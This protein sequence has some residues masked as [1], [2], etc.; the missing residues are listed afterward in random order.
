MYNSI[1]INEFPEKKI[2]SGI[3]L[4]LDEMISKLEYHNNDDEVSATET[5]IYGIM[6]DMIDKIIID[7]DNIPE[8]EDTVSITE[9]EKSVSLE[10]D[11]NIVLP[12]PPTDIEKYLYAKEPKR[13]QI[14]LFNILPP[15]SYICSIL[16]LSTVSVDTLFLV[17]IAAFYFFY[18]AFSY[19][20]FGF[21]SF[22]FATH[23]SLVSSFTPFRIDYIPSVDVFLPIC[24]EPIAVIQNTW[25][26]VSQLEYPHMNIYVLND[27]ADKE[28][29]RALAG[30]Y[31]FTYIQRTDKPHLKK[32]GNLRNA[33][34]QT[35][36]DYIAI[37]DADFC[38]RHDFLLETIPIMVAD[39]S[40][41]ILQTPQYFR[42]L[43]NQTWVE[44]Q[45][46]F[47][48]ETF[49][50]VSQVDKNVYECPLCVGTNAIYRREA[51]RAFG[52]TAEVEDSEDVNT[53]VRVMLNGYKV[54]YIPIV[55]ATGTNPDNTQAFFF[56]QYRWCIGSTKLLTS[57]FLWGSNLG[58]MQK[59]CF[60]NGFL[61]YFTT[62]GQIVVKILYCVLLLFVYPE[63]VLF[64]NV[65]FLVPQLL[66]ACI[67]IRITSSQPYTCI[68]IRIVLFQ[69]Y[70]FAMA[71]LDFL[72]NNKMEWV[73]TGAVTQR[74]GSNKQYRYIASLYS[75]V[76]LET[77]VFV[78]TVASAIIHLPSI[79]NFIPSLIVSAF[80]MIQAW[81]II[82]PILS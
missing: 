64:F 38:P 6:D 50:K 24:N 7:I 71:F 56:Q 54:K 21:H 77:A 42:C 65:L 12:S 39:A 82:M 37:F 3:H 81:N 36:G 29:I 18:C 57:A 75:M 68:P 35:T 9:T 59:V 52:G 10:I 22:D 58:F 23:Q 79:Y 45:S 49:Y 41:G 31:G 15:F 48:Q 69:Q 55:L 33:Y 16:L 72:R 2:L 25:K 28:E 27:G 76:T 8:M 20:L 14:Y 30:H 32:A 47:V 78:C 73:S 53:G 80:Y 70:V 60:F 13:G 46:G 1:Q 74:G 4:I 34:K 26:Y 62:A 44:Q 5:E 19:F 43:P 17:V 40:L 51:T 11:T 66:N 63:K 61:Y 67:F